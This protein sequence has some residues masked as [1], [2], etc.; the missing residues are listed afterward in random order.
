[1]DKGLDQ[2]MGGHYPVLINKP[3][4]DVIGNQKKIYSI[5]RN[6]FGDY[7]LDITIFYVPLC[8]IFLNEL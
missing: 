8:N 3:L 1:L 5:I 4:Y 7:L 2:A 6:F